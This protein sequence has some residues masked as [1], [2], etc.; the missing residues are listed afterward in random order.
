MIIMYKVLAIVLISNLWS[1]SADIIPKR[2]DLIEG[3]LSNGLT[4]YILKNNKPEN[5]AELRLAVNVGSI[6]EDDDQQGFAHLIEH[7]CFNGTKKYPKSSLVEYLT[8]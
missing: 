7:M 4:Y 2:S 5:R 3:K 1:V 6:D 8:S